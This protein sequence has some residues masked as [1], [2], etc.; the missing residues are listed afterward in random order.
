MRGVATIDR[1]PSAD[2]IAVWVTSSAAQA[3]AGHV[4]A[5]VMPAD[6]SDTHEKIR[7]LTRCCVV[8]ATDGSTL[9]GL[10]IEGNVLHAADLADLLA[11]TEK[12]QSRIIQA[13]SEYRA[14]TRSVVSRP[15]FPDW[16][17]RRDFWPDG[18]TA[19]AHAFATANYL[20]A[21]WSVWLKSDDER[22]KRTVQPRTGVTPWIM[23]EDMN[24]PT[25][26]PFPPEFASRFTEQALV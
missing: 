13:I 26:P 17:D 14:K 24:Q 11:E 16:P 2:Q 15:T 22:L 1:R 19:A 12:H 20:Q 5:V 9:E 3:G 10:P 4:N 21:V 18:H 8:L 6:A 23:P 7:S 25:T